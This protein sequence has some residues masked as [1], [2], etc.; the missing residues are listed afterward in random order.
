MSICI[1]SGVDEELLGGFVGIEKKP[2]DA[3][4][5]VPAVN[6]KIVYSPRGLVM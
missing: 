1:G 4:Q 5:C 3:L 6:S 2:N